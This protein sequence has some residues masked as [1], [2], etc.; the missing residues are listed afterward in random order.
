MKLTA[1]WDKAPYKVDWCFGGAYYRHHQGDSS[2]LARYPR[3]LP[4]L[5]EFSRHEQYISYL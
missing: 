3:N 1:F 2:S 5:S 4:N